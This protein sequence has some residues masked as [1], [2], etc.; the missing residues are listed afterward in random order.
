MV[1][2]TIKAARRAL[3]HPYNSD[4]AG[5]ARE[6]RPDQSITLTPSK[7]RTSRAHH[8]QIQNINPARR[9]T[10]LLGLGRCS[11][12]RNLVAD[13]VLQG[14]LAG[15]ELIRSPVWPSNAE[16]AIR[17]TLLQTSGY[18]YVVLFG[19]PVRAVLVLSRA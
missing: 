15:H 12:Y 8:L 6:G 18:R 13:M 11:R 7:S 17:S 2:R 19:L 16:L 10:S 1:G 5:L 9:R 4:G 14:D 3:K